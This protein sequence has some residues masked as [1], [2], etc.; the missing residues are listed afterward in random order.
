MA[1]KYRIKLSKTLI[2]SIY[3]Q[4][5]IPV[6]T[7]EPWINTFEGDFNSEN[8]HVYNLIETGYFDN[9]IADFANTL[10]PIKHPVFLRFAHE[11]DNPFYPWY[12]TGDK[13]SEKLKN[14][15]IHTY[16][17]FQKN[18]ARIMWY[19]FGTRGNR[20]MLPLFIQ[21]KLMLIGLRKH[22]K[23]RRL[24]SDGKSQ[25]FE[26]LYKPIPRRV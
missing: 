4:N 23:L 5:S 9:Y 16:E 20:S 25:E 12:V 15:W 6:I 8:H 14:A 26:A 13:A 21:A 19:G 24:K 17:I 22:T 18:K 7:W 10:K 11:F 2:D 1:Q 3:K